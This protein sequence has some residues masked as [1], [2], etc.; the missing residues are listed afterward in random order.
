MKSEAAVPW[1]VRRVPG[2]ENL[3]TWESEACA[4]PWPWRDSEWSILSW[5]KLVRRRVRVTESDAPACATAFQ[6]KRTADAIP[7]SR[8]L[9]AAASVP[10]KRTMAD[11]T[12]QQSIQSSF[13]LEA[14]EDRRRT[15]ARRGEST[16]RRRERAALPAHDL[17]AARA[18]QYYQPGARTTTAVAFISWD[19][20]GHGRLVE[21]TSL[22]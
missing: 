11:R 7:A 3:A 9:V 2:V 19:L 16:G 13:A 15:R 1:A 6:R 5:K 17:A 12:G 8:A 4:W 21:M 10:T 14:R 18:A 20:G 22:Y